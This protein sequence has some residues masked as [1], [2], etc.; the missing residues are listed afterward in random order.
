MKL[1]Y[2][3]LDAKEKA[4]LQKYKPQGVE[5]H[6]LTI[7][8]SGIFCVQFSVDGENEDSAKKLS[9]IDVH[10]R[11]NYSVTVLENGCSTYFNR[12]LY[13]IIATFELKLRKLLYLSASV[14][15]DNKL[16]G[17]IVD[18]ESKDFGQIFTMLFI[19]DSFMNN[20]KDKIKARNKETFS[21]ADVLALI[22]SVNEKPLWDVLLAKDVVPT[23]RTRFCEVRLYRNDVMHSHYINWVKYKEIQ[24]LFNSIDSEFDAALH[25][26]EI[27]EIVDQINPS[28][29]ETLRSALAMQKTIA[30]LTQTLRPAIEEAKRLSELYTMSPAI[31][32][33]QKQLHALSSVKLDISPAIKSMQEIS[34][35]FSSFKIETPPELLKLQESLSQLN[36]TRGI[37][38][39]KEDSNDAELK[40]DG[41]E[42]NG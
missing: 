41:S 28:F 32:E 25:G 9:D 34:K 17:N 6:F 19:D 29:N 10:I 27:K 35:R 21:K 5:K 33:M 11:Q 22:E 14:A 2:L 20:I 39:L 24:K 3:L 36:E 42:N 38:D 40:S 30:E 4:S 23:L 12:R 16:A 7:G 15:S 37:Q 18:L 31:A 1:E 13:P 8:K 26:I